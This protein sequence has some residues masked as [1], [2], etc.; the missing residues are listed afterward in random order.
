MRI[1]NLPLPF[2]APVYPIN[3]SSANDTTISFLAVGRKR[4]MQQK[5]KGNDRNR[6]MMLQRDTN[7]SWWVPII[8]HRKDPYHM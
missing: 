5:E 3:Q 6:G 2:F 7:Q 4:V 8:Y 1:V